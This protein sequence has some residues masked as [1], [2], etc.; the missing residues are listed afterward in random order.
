MGREQIKVKIN[1]FM[2]WLVSHY[3]DEERDNMQSNSLVQSI[4]NELKEVAESDT[5]IDLLDRSTWGNNEFSRAEDLIWNAVAPRAAHQQRVENLVQTAGFLGK[6][7]VDEARRTARSKIHCLYYRDF[8]TWSLK[9]VRKHRLDVIKKKKAQ[10]EKAKAQRDAVNPNT[11]ATTAQTTNQSTRQ[12]K[13]IT[14]P[15]IEEKLRKVEG[16]LYLE[17][18]SQWIDLKTDKIDNNNITEIL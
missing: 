6:T 13:K 10:A 17:M 18:F 2:N 15:K 4:I 7:H 8:K 5:V 14:A 9:V 1:E 3:S 11:T 16:G 12:P